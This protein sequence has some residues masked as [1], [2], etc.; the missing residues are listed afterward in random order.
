MLH[1]RHMKDWELGLSPKEYQFLL[2]MANY[3]VLSHGSASGCCNFMQEDRE[4][5]LSPKECQFLLLM[6]NYAVLSHGSASGCCNFMQ[7]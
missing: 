4:L 2:L 3:A 7:E 1:Y 6:A 5:G